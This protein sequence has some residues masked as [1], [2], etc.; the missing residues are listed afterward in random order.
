[1]SSIKQKSSPSIQLAYGFDALISHFV[2]IGKKFTWHH[3]CEAIFTLSEKIKRENNPQEAKKLFDF[4]INFQ[5]KLFD[6]SATLYT[7]S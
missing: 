1:M 4:G 2:G 3:I 6:A 7:E 5:K